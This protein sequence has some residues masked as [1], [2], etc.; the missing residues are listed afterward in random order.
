M[1]ESPLK[2]VQAL[3]ASS[4]KRDYD[5]R[6]KPFSPYY[7]AGSAL[8]RADHVL[9][10]DSRPR[11]GLRTRALSDAPGNQGGISYGLL[12][13]PARVY[14]LLRSYRVTHLLWD[15]GKSKGADSIAGEL[16][17]HHF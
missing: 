7:E 5:K 9:V 11:A 2:S 6:L 4:Q 8:D 15:T 17:F 3:F 1:V 14:E 16:V 12:D 13:S 10:H